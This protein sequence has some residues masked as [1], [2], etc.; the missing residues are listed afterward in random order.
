MIK[1]ERFSK[2][3]KFLVQS[4]SVSF[5]A[6][7]Y[8]IRDGVGTSYKFNAA[9]QKALD[10]LEYTRTGGKYLGISGIWEEI[11]IQLDVV[12]E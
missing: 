5:Y 11:P 4:G 12:S 6:L 9:T 7:A 1:M 2:K 10:A 3:Q 8:E